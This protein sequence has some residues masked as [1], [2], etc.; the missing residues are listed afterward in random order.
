MDN[1]NENMER[2]K[3]KRS[4]PKQRTTNLHRFGRINLAK[5]FSYE[6]ILL[7]LIYINININ[8]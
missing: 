3:R 5:Y 4:K 8:N 2:E 7:Y 1:E 6:V